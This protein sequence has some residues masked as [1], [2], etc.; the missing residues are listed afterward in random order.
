MLFSFVVFGLI[1]TWLLIHRFRLEQLEERLE[2][3]GLEHALAARRAEGAPSSQSA[4]ESVH[5]A[6]PSVPA[7]HAGEVRR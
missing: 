2:T 1:Y 3:D 5:A 6:A 4:D 7:I